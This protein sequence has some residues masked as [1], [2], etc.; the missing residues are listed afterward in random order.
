MYNIVYDLKNNIN[1]YRLYIP[2]LTGYILSMFCGIP[3]DSGSNLPQRPPAFVFKIVWP[4]LYILLGLVW[5]KSYTQKYLDLIFTLI[6]FL[7]CLWIFVFSCQNNKKN[8]IYIIAIT[9]ATVICSMTLNND[10]ISKILLI[11]LL[12]WLLIAYQ[13]N[14]DILN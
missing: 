9:I 7:L 10:N 6:T 4:I 2:A 1:N 13:L 11:P 3:K 12:S 14:W 8:G 5:S